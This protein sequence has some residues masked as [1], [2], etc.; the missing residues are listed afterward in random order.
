MSFG[1]VQC[2]IVIVTPGKTQLA[3]ISFI[4]NYD[5]RGDICLHGSAPSK[6]FHCSEGIFFI[7]HVVNTEILKTNRL[8]VY[9][10]QNF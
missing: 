1:G 8:N 5:L 10:I 6:F 3:F 7:Q 2:Q 4:Q 9:K